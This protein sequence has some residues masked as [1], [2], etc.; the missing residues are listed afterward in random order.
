MPEPPKTRRVDLK[1]LTP[2]ERLIYR[3]GCGLEDGI[4]HSV[5]EIAKALGLPP[6]HVTQIETTIAWKL[7]YDS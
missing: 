3:M 6:A 2:R 1:A 5:E 4:D 7:G